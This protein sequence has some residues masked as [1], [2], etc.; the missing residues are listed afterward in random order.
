MLKK[1]G[2]ETGKNAFEKPILVMER[3]SFPVLVPPTITL[4]VW[5]T[6]SSN[7]SWKCVFLHRNI[8]N[9][10]QVLKHW[11]TTSGA[12]KPCARRVAVCLPPPA[13]VFQILDRAG[14]IARAE[15]VKRVPLPVQ[16]LLQEVQMDFKDVTT[17]SPDP[18]A[19]SEK[20]QHLVE[21]CHFVDAGSSRLL[22][23]QVHEDFHAE[24]AFEAVI[25]FLRKYG[26]PV[27]LTMDR[28]VLPSSAARPSAIF[29]RPCSS[30]CI[31]LGSIPTSFHLTILS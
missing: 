16:G 30:S 6:K 3:C 27:M 8:S 25:Q 7:G 2:H 20:K 28:D 9:A 24:T 19:P 13:R 15:P 31:V 22:S 17:V 4:P 12:M 18:T 23:A 1:Y 10:R 14:L 26:L 29:P 11:C 21:V 5:L